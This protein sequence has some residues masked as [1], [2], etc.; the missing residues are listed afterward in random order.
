MVFTGS[1]AQDVPCKLIAPY[2]VSK[3]GVWILAR[4]AAREL[5][6]YGITVNAVAPGIVDAGLTA[7]ELKD[8]PKFREE[9]MNLIP[10]GRIQTAED[11]A[12][13]VGF[14]I[15]PAADYLTGACIM[16]DGGCMIG[17]GSASK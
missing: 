9:F 12:D 10:L 11:V 1:W 3:A 8:F 2:C 13:V 6:P 17:C 7:R 15:S 16:A 4:C 14:L 5:A